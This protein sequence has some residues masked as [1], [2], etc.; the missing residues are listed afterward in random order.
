MNE[1]INRSSRVFP[2]RLNRCMHNSVYHNDCLHY[3]AL[4]PETIE[5]LT[6][7]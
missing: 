7:Y 4:F 1:W 2:P 6:A 3:R 5:Y